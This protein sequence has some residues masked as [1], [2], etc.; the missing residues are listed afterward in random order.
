MFMSISRHQLA[1]KQCFSLKV[2]QQQQQLNR[3]QQPQ[4]QQQ[5]QLQPVTTGVKMPRE[6]KAISSQQ[7]LF[8][9]FSSQ[10]A[11]RRK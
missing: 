10:P 11:S 8:G 2:Q 3:Q 4:E 7:L 6:E 5:Q 1:N 9:Q